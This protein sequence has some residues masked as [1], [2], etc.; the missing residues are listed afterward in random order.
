M[1]S[2]RKGH[3]K[4]DMYSITPAVRL[5]IG[6][7]DIVSETK[8]FLIRHGVCLDSF[9]KCNTVKSTETLIAKNLPA[10]TT[11]KELC[12]FIQ[13]KLRENDDSFFKPNIIL[14]PHG[15]CAIIGFNNPND[16]KRAFKSLEN[17][18][19]SNSEQEE[20]VVILVKNI[21]FEAEHKEISQ[22][23][24]VYGRLK[25]VHLPTKLHE[26]NRRHRGF[27][28]VEFLTTGDALNAY[29]SLRFSTHLYGRRLVLEWAENATSLDILRKRA[30][31]SALDLKPFKQ[32]KSVMQTS[33][34]DENID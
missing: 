32:K 29:E 19:S 14:P 22:L 16:A 13:S 12:E 31:T 10:E 9:N 6:E 7:T 33:N 20:R 27:A 11:R 25:R 8:E 21:P 26:S 24:S 30:A 5:A 2:S 17:K 3:I 28:F 18:S 15:I 1:K 34:G 4:S 23:F